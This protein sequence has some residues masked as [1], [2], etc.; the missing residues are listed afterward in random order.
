M[1]GNRIRRQIVFFVQTAVMRPINV[2]Y[3]RSHRSIDSGIED[4]H[5]SGT[6]AIA[7]EFHPRHVDQGLFRSANKSQREQTLRYTLN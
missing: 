2:V 5:E 6:M 1:E 4:T 7:W 3:L